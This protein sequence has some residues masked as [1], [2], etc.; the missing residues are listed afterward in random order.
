MIGLNKDEIRIRRREM[1][2]SLEE[3]TSW[4]LNLFSEY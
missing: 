4:K 2:A 1:N 3:A